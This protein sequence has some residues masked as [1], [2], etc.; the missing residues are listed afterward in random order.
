MKQLVIPAAFDPAAKTVDFSNVAG[1]DPGHLLAIINTTSRAVLYDPVTSGMGLAAFANGLAT[2]QT[3]VSGQSSTDRLIAFYDDGQIPAV[4]SAQPSLNADG[5]ALTH[6]TNFPATQPISGTVTTNDGGAAI[7]GASLPAGGIGVTGWLSSIWA[8]LAG[9]LNVSGS[10][11]VANFPASQSIS[12]AVSV[13]NLPPTQAVSVAALPLPA[14]AATSANQP[15]LNADGGAM[16][17]VTNWPTSFGRAWALSSESDSVV[18]GT[19]TATIGAISNTIFATTQSGAW[20]VSINGTPNVAVANFPATQAVSASSLPLPSGAA[21]ATLQNSILSALQTVLE[22]NLYVGGAAAS[23]SNPVPI[24]DAYQ[25]ATAA[26]WSNA[27]AANTALTVNTAGYDTVIFT[28]SPA[29]GLTAGSISFEAFDGTNWVA[30]KAP[31]TDSYYTDSTFSLSGSPG[32]HSWQLPV[33]GYPQTRARLSTAISGSG[34]VGL[35]CIVSSAPDVSLVTVGLDP[36]QPLPAGSNTIGAVNIANFP[37]TQA[38]SDSQSAPFAGAVAMTV[39]VTYASQRS[40][41]VLCTSAGNVQ[42]QFGDGSTL[43]LPAGVGWQTFPFAITQ[44]VAAG[45]TATANYFNLK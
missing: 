19:G 13:T 20:S 45:T 27:T 10:I 21:T 44:V 34:T 16:A 32:T 24:Y 2:L 36:N 26:N 8:K 17:H 6:V 23:S 14:G 1:F 4:A 30:I 28:V 31:R 41:G 9:T 7:T 18:L 42:M 40:L 43:I 3:N 38:V 15:T 22:T 12:G 39:G 5:G 25:A 29:A 11:S 37:A 35:V 33:A